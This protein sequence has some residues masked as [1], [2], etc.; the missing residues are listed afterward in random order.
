MSTLTSAST[1]DEINAAYAD[2]ASYDEDNSASKCKAFITACRLLLIK[3]PAMVRSGGRHEVQMNT[4]LIQAAMNDAQRW[5][6]SGSSGSGSAGN[7]GI[8]F[9]N[10]RGNS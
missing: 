2:N 9:A 3:I 7:I 5:K 6:S 1:L 8:S 4:S 10:F